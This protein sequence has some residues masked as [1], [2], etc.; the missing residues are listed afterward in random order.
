M[1]YHLDLRR[2]SVEAYGELLKGQNLLP[3]RRILLQNID[4]R[5]RVI[6]NCGIK[7]ILELKGA[8]STP[9]KIMPFAQKSGLPEEYLII[10][11][12]EIG[13]LTPKPVPIADFPGL[14]A[15]RVQALRDAGIKTSRDYFESDP[16]QSDDEIFSLCDLVRI[17]G[18]GAVAA[19]AFFEAGYRSVSDVAG[20]DAAQMLLK[21]S[22]VNQK[23][24][25][26]KVRLGIKD[27]RFC[28]DFASLLAGFCG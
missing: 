26:Y 2:L 13:S 1:G 12:R 21:V 6:E 9:V 4:E 17:N 3:G 18:V 27:M 23:R 24:K 19:R 20:A 5:F 28:I 7:N 16:L 11:K 22:E 8:L 25:Y 15:G 10:L 14:D